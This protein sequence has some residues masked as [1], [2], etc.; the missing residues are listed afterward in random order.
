M[1]GVGSGVGADGSEELGKKT[2][3]ALMVTSPY[4]SQN[5][6]SGVSPRPVIHC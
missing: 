2:E 6:K 3:P 5:S 1:S 4:H